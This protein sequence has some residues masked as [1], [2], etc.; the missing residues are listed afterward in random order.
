[1]ILHI[2]NGDSAGFE[3][4][5]LFPQDTVLTW[6]D[7]LTDGPVPQGLTLEAF[8]ITRADFLAGWSETPAATVLAELQER[9][10]L[11]ARHTDF[12][13][14][15]LWFEHDLYDQLQL[16]QI[17]DW[18]NGRG[19]NLTLAQSN[20]Y[21][22]VMPLAAI[23]KL[24]PLRQP[25]SRRQ[26]EL[27][28]AAW[29]AFTSP[30]PRELERFLDQDAALP[31]LAAAIKRFCEEYPWTEDG[32]TRTE[33]TIARLR[34]DGITDP[35]ELF[36]AFSKTED[37]LWMGDDS[38]FRILEGARDRGSDWMWDSTRSRFA[39]RPS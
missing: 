4:Q 26:F 2:T 17:L 24:F 7:S 28:S 33:R 32:L 31:Y 27:A 22:G 25:V 34:A 29:S 19:V 21:L 35:R 1:V 18:Y 15:V 3:L 9:N 5:K 23:A 38:F 20:D 13:E 10:A 36:V 6:R 14:T 11:L 12:S 16:I 37:P 30:D 8:S 39:H